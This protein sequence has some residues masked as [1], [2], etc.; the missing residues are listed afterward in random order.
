[1][2]LATN[3]PSDR[4]AAAM[5]YDS[6][7]KRTV[8]FGGSAA[9]NGPLDE[10][11]EHDGSKWTK[12]ATATAVAPRTGACMAYDA[13]RGVAVMFGGRS[14]NTAR[15]AE[16]WEWNGKDWSLGP[17]GPPARRSCAMAYDAVRDAVVLVGGSSAS[18]GAASAAD[19]D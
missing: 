3:G 10:T 19:S 11:W 2:R 17:S 1:L 7:R 14:G 4:R 8:L 15:L 5:A 16:T 13:G 18:D 9:Q 6:V 12:I